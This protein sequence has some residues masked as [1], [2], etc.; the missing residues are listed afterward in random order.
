[1]MLENQERGKEVII[2]EEKGASVFWG[3]INATNVSK[4]TRAIQSTFP[5]LIRITY[6]KVHILVRS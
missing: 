4:K 1:M 2:A 6:Q 5:L 3:D